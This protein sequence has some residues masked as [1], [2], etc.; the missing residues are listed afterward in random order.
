MLEQAAFVKLLQDRRLDRKIGQRVVDSFL[1]FA[2]RQ[3]RAQRHPAAAPTQR[4][5]SAHFK[6]QVA[7]FLTELGCF[8]PIVNLQPRNDR[9]LRQAASDR[10]ARCKG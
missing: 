10:A 4:R 2:V 1:P 6:K 5:K 3:I 8:A 7:L 9:V